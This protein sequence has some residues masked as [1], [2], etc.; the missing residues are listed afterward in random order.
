VPVA[1]V[2]QAQR[3][4][5]ERWGCPQA[6]R[7]D[8]GIPWGASNGLPTVYGLW[9]AGLG[10]QMVWNEPYRP[11]QNGVVERSQGVTQ[12]WVEPG[13]CA[14]L[15]E[16][17]RRVQHEDY[18]QRE[19]YPAIDG[20]SRREAY[21]F[22]LHSGRGYCLTWEKM[23]WELSDALGLL[24][25]YQVRRKV[26]K[27]GQVSAYHRLIQVGSQYAE[28]WVYLRMDAQTG[29]WVISDVA[30][31]EVRRRPAPQFTAAAI[32]GLSLVAP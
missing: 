24:G 18:I 32:V 9:L 23:V 11:Q 22:L 7:V 6:V 15:E 16:L 8:N 10:V 21:P 27:R 4:C 26:S 1:Q 14:N 31:K 28:Q 25:R 19:R 29:E 13:K 3:N 5:F 17:R 20:K 12:S 2:Q 30:G